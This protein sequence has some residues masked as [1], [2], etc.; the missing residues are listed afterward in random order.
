MGH[1]SHEN[2]YTTDVS[3]IWAEE[4]YM[5]FHIPLMLVVYGKF[6]HIQLHSIYTSIH[7]VNLI[8][9]RIPRDI[10]PEINGIM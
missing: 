7:P 10:Q 4:W 2:S 9:N 1:F 8:P 6:S 3:G 5:D